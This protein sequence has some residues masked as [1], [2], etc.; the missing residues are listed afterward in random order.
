[1]LH[2]NSNFSQKLFDHKILCIFVSLELYSDWVCI[3]RIFFHFH[4]NIFLEYRYS[5]MY[6]QKCHYLL[7]LQLSYQDICSCIYFVWQSKIYFEHCICYHKHNHQLNNIFYMNYRVGCIY[8]NN[9]IY[10]RL[11]HM[12]IYFQILSHND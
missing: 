8:L 12:K 11:I 4:N 3:V 2:S 1:M 10:D 9:K 6:N 5:H 7:G